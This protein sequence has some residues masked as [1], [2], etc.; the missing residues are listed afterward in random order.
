MA[1]ESFIPITDVKQTIEKESK[2]MPSIDERTT[3]EVPKHLK[4]PFLK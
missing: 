4:K 1:V 3:I 2:P